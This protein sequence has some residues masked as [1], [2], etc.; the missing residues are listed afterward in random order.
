MQ[1]RLIEENGTAIF[2]RRFTWSGKPNGDCPATGYHH[3]ALVF[4]E[5]LDRIIGRNEIVREGPG[6]YAGDPRWPVACQACGY[7]FADTDEWQ[8][9]PQRRFN[10]QSGCPEAG[11]LF[12]VPYAGDDERPRH[13][14]GV[15]PDGWVWDADGPASNGGGWTRT[16][17]P[18]MITCSPSIMTPSYHG[19]LRQGEWSL[20]TDG[21]TYPTGLI[22]RSWRELAGLLPR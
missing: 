1:A 14:H 21:R 22:V 18:P 12:W 16:G 7:E 11:D 15:C 3:N 6:V 17:E 19:W 10:T 5:A 20:D 2:L 9:F 4:V 8:V 13:L